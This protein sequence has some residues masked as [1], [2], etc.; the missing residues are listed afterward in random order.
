MS[1]KDLFVQDDSEK[2]EKVGS[3][4][5]RITPKWEPPLQNIKPPFSPT[6]LGTE[7]VNN[8]KQQ[9]Q[10]TSPFP[11]LGLS[12]ADQDKIYQ[13]IFHVTEV[14]E[15]TAPGLT[16]VVHLMKTLETTIPDAQLRTK[17]AYTIATS[18]GMPSGQ[19]ASDV[20]RLLNLLYAEGKNASDK[21]NAKS[22]EADAEDQAIRKDEGLIQVR[23]TQL[24]EKRARI[25][26][27]LEGVDKAVKHREADLLALKTQVG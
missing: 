27:Q 12:N 15:A 4:T 26:S 3:P 14:T 6:P 1:F 11:P 5:G 16:K 24:A 25:K 2:N 19:P 23:K 13:G 20:D 10:A 8:L 18:Q 21:L 7:I 17:T 9:S 22:A